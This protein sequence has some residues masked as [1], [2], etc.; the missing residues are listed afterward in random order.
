M[1]SPQVMNG[2]YWFIRD[3]R[4]FLAGNTKLCSCRV[5]VL[6]RYVLGNSQVDGLLER[7]GKNS[8]SQRGQSF[9]EEIYN[10]ET[11]AWLG[12]ML[13]QDQTQ[14]LWKCLPARNKE[15]PQC[16]RKSHFMKLWCSRAYHHWI[17]KYNAGKELS[18]FCFKRRCWQKCQGS[19]ITTSVSTKPEPWGQL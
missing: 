10:G 16:N 2:T 15:G 3:L 18:L 1:S 13:A 6:H 19:S 5:L 4:I 11:E 9:E 14:L 7:E 17:A 12:W 8:V